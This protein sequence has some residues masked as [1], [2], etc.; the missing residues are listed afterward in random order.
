[1]IWHVIFI[2]IINCA[3]NI[4]KIDNV[5]FCVIAKLTFYGKC[6]YKERKLA[7]QIIAGDVVAVEKHMDSI[8]N[9]LEYKNVNNLVQ[10]IVGEMYLTPEMIAFL[11]ARER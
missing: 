3:K 1:M 5:V 8:K 11:A 7:R 10:K 2:D 9:K 6:S 4:I